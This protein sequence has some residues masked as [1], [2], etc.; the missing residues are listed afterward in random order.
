MYMGRLGGSCFLE[1]FGLRAIDKVVDAVH[2]VR[3]KLAVAVA[4]EG[5]LLPTRPARSHFFGNQI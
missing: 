3:H 5:E 2:G 1:P 4:N